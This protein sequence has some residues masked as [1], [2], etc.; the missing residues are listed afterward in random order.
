MIGLPAC[1]VRSA[2]QGG[3]CM[4]AHPSVSQKQVAP[5]QVWPALSNDLRIR[6]IG[7]LAHLALNV[8]VPRPGGEESGKEGVHADPQTAAQNRAFPS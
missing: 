1:S 7:L 6:V 2:L 5:G 4:S 8:V 3:L